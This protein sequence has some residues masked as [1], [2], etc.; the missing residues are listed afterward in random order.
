MTPTKKKPPK[1]PPVLPQ[2]NIGP[3]YN[4]IGVVLMA[5]G[6]WLMYVHSMRKE[7]FEWEEVGFFAV[8]ILLY[9]LVA[10][11]SKFDAII[12]T[13]ADKLPFLSYKKDK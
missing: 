3:A 2:D 5:G 12:K 7:K 1:E 10:R 9:T 13:I 11:P 4:F 6:M 8:V